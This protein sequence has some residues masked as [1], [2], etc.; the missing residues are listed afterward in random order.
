MFH[1]C[2]D[3]QLIETHISWLVLLGEYAYKLKKP[4]NF[5][6]IDCSTLALRKHYCE[7][8]VRLNR[9]TAPD[10][11]VDVQP[12]SGTETSPRLGDDGQPI[13][14]AVR[15]HRFDNALLMDRLAR[16]NRLDEP[17]VVALADAIA[18]FHASVTRLRPGQE[19]ARPKAVR[20]PVED[21]FQILETMMS[22]SPQ[23]EL[24]DPL[25]VWS[26]KEFHRRESV[27]E[28]RREA[29]FV[30]ECHGDL[31]LGN[32]LYQEGRCILF[33]CIDFN[34]ELR[35]IDTASDIAF[36]L[37]DL[38]ARV[39]RQQ[40]MLLLNEYFQLTGDYG[41]ISVMDYYKVYRALV[42]AKVAAIRA[43]QDS[44]QSTRLQRDIN[45]HLELAAGFTQSRQ[46]FMLIMSGASGTGKTW[47]ARKLATS[48]EAIHIRSDVERK[49]LY[50][51]DIVSDSHA[52]G[53]DIYTETANQRTFDA[54]ARLSGEI[55]AES[56]PVILDATFI[57]HGL[58]QRFVELAQR[59]EVPWAI[60]A[61]EA[62]EAVVKTRLAARE[63]DASEAGFQQYLDQMARM[64][65]F[66]EAESRHLVR[67]NTAADISVPDL[68]ARIRRQWN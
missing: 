32:I 34:D 19:F 17:V 57:D 45:D 67:V 14:Y 44:T 53:L 16:A 28:Q 46:P 42:R 49:R 62:P 11:Y 24:L 5:G 65:A 2:D 15:M 18:R 26:D 33:D 37:M 52:R 41:A 7:E 43:D 30:R 9:R 55:I 35:W 4:V 54:L 13:E 56:Y 38:E 23:R 31:H 39:G 58:R 50:K 59:L 40:A 21:T 25:R 27:F 51:L 10:I 12:I 47:L 36:T 22:Q 61:S 60:V 8:E 48:L 64:D 63:G 1:A 6:F 29:G 68:A 3:P 20:T 66:D